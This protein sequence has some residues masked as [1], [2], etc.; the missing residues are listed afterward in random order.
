[1]L[2]RDTNVYKRQK[3][4]RL[5]LIASFRAPF[6]G[7]GAKEPKNVLLSFQLS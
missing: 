7:L 2:L 4:E 5:S 1:M 3:S 6:D